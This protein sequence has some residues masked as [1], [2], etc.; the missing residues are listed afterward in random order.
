MKYCS[1]CGKELDDDAIICV[2]CGCTAPN[3]DE[4][5]AKV[6]NGL[7]IAAKILMIISTVAM[8]FLIIPLIWCIPMTVTYC[9]KIKNNEP[10]SIGFKICI[11]LFVDV[12]AGIL[13]LIDDFKN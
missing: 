2:N 7:R 3:S 9:N 10:I 4:K 12:I 6:S 1:H 13:L 11:L 5:K 8:G